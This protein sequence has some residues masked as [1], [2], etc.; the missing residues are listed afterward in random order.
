MLITNAN[1]TSLTFDN[2]GADFISISGTVG[3]VGPLNDDGAIFYSE[4]EGEAN[5]RVSDLFP[6]VDANRIY[7]KS[8]NRTGS[9]FVSHV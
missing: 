4:G 7:A 6:G 1:V 8:Q 9:I 2:K 5:R 3:A